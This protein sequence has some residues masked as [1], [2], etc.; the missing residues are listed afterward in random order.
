MFE[1]DF[2]LSSRSSGEIAVDLTRNNHFIKDYT[3]KMTVTC[4]Q[5]NCN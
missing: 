1:H 3:Q 2:S 5:T 4:K